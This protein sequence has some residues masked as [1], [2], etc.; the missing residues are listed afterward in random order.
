[1]KEPFKALQA[2]HRLVGGSFG[3]DM[4]YLLYKPPKKLDPK[5]KTAA[6]IITDIY[7]IAHAE[8]SRCGHPEWEKIKDEI[9][10]QPEE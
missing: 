9:M 8:I 4:E 3:M 1:M 7:C 10:K 5:L 6:R 2:I